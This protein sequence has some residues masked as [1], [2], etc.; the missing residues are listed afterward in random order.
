[1]ADRLGFDRPGPVILEESVEEGESLRSLLTRL[2]GRFLHFSEVLFNPETQSLS[3]EVTILINGHI[4]LP[5]G[6]DTKLNDGDR[7]LF[8][9]I[10][11]GG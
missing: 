2:A 10:L 8:L 3:S 11:A 5:Q 4:Y 7:I 9:P 6:M 1:M